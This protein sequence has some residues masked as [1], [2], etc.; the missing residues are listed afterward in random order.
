MG[1]EGLGTASKSPE[2][3]YEKSQIMEH[4]LWFFSLSLP[5][6]RPNLQYPTQLGLSYCYVSIGT[7]GKASEENQLVCNDK[8]SQDKRQRGGGKKKA[9]LRVCEMGQTIGTHGSGGWESPRSSERKR[10]GKKAGAAHPGEVLPLGPSWPA[11]GP[12]AGRRPRRCRRRPRRRGSRTARRWRPS[13]TG[14]TG[15]GQSPR[16]RNI[17][18]ERTRTGNA[19]VRFF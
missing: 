14:R 12:A 6:C 7:G 1:V 4:F 3:A 18:A 13:N 15:F 10:K 9:G 2:V 16:M 5:S 17:P 8:L 19:C 11:R